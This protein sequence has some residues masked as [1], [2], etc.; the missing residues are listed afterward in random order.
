MGGTGTTIGLGA[1]LACPLERDPNERLLFFNPVGTLGAAE[2]GGGGGGA[3]GST[4][5]PYDVWLLSF[6][7]AGPTPPIKGLCVAPVPVEFRLL[8]LPVLLVP[9]LPAPF[10]INAGLLFGGGGGGQCVGLDVD[11]VG[12]RGRCGAGAR[13]PTDPSI[14][15][16]KFCA[17]LNFIDPPGPAPGGLG[18]GFNV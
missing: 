3:G 13:L 6:K 15:L 8:L 12:F 2:S 16:V 18:A 9:P 11:C 1:R 10:I 17:L 5:D 4:E 14:L 7:N